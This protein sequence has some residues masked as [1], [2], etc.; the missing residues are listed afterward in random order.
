MKSLYYLPTH[1]RIKLLGKSL[2]LSSFCNTF[3]LGFVQS[4]TSFRLSSLEITEIY[5]R[6]ISVYPASRFMWD[7]DSTVGVCSRGSTI[8]FVWHKLIVSDLENG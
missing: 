5:G 1:Q 2:H 7:D 3:S 8:I 4:T 6:V